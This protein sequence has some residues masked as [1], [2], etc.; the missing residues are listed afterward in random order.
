MKSLVGDT[1]ATNPTDA[2]RAYSTGLASV[3]DRWF[4][5]ERKRP[6][7]A[8]KWMLRFGFCAVVAS[9]PY[10]LLHRSVIGPVMT[11]FGQTYRDPFSL[12][13]TRV[14]VEAAYQ[15]A[16]RSAVFAAL[17]L[18]GSQLR[19]LLGK[20]SA[21]D[22]SVAALLRLR[23][24]FVPNDWDRLLIQV[25]Q[26][27]LHRIKLNVVTGDSLKAQSIAVYLKAAFEPNQDFFTRLMYWNLTYEATFGPG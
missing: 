25:I 26:A 18:T 8:H 2:F 19:A 9:I 5:D 21:S 20:A 12:E 6:D 14:L 27:E 7:R 1:T 24:L 22:D 17:E 16:G 23:T 13:I 11:L 4:V 15:H 10:A 3:L